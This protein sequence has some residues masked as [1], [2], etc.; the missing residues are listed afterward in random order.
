MKN[1][2]DENG[3]LILKDVIPRVKIDE[4]MQKNLEIV[5]QVTQKK[6]LDL[7]DKNLI[8]FYD[9]HPEIETKVYEAIQDQPWIT[10][11]TKQKEIIQ[12]VKE[13][14]GE[15]VGV[16]GKAPFRMD[17][18]FWT[19]D[20]AHWHQDFFYVKGNTRVVTVWIPM[21]DTKYIH[22]CISIMPKTHHLGILEHNVRVGRKMIPQSIFENEIKLVEVNKGDIVLFSSLLLHSSNINCSEQIRYS[23]QPRYTPLNEES[24]KGMKGVIPV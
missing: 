12:H 16:F 4:L 21:Q 2:Y 5:N 14:L 20:M 18:P 17:M 6:F 11:F 8:K 10:E 3:Y 22:G 7:N 24:D 23:I 13:I 15:D 19:K 9:E 1:T